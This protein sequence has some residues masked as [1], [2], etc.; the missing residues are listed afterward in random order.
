MVRVAQLDR[1]PDCESGGCEI[2]SHRAPQTTLWPNSSG[3][4]LQPARCRCESDQG[5][6]DHCRLQIVDFRLTS[7]VAQSTIC[8]LKSTI[9]MALSSN[10]QDVRL[11]TG[12]YGGSTRRGYQSDVAQRQRGGLI[13]RRMVVQ[14]HPSLPMPVRCCERHTPLVPGKR[15]GRSGS[16]LQNQ[17][18]SY[19]C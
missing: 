17:V 14:L 5:L 3:E 8:N 18:V 1:A 7:Q 15:R 2:I 4:R 10:S 9:D 11:S 6:H 19:E 16:R 13:T 12:R